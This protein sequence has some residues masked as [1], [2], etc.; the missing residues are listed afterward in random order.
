MASALMI[1]LI[2]LDTIPSLL[3]LLYL[4]PNYKTL[5]R[6]RNYV[7]FFILSQFILNL[8]A[9]I[10]ERYRIEN[11]NIYHLNCVV[12]FLLLS[13][14]F[15]SIVLFKQIKR[16]ANMVGIIFFI[17]FVIDITTIE[18]F[19][20]FN[21]YSYGLASFILTTYSL[22]YF[23]K[24]ISYPTEIVITKTKD[25]WFITGIFTYY[26]CNFLIFLSINWIIQTYS[27]TIFDL[28]WRIHNVILAIMCIYFFFG[29][30]CK[31]NQ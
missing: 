29:F 4:L 14:Y 24:Q 28:I 17:C 12:S 15:K 20:T 11:V 21:S 26:A 3:L 23:L 13:E 22:I 16:I 8:T 25:F 7:F 27:I 18:N 10:L 31:L 1:L 5:W 9:G 6:R 2:Y 19:N 30:R